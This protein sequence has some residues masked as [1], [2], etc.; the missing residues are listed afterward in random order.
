MII[1]SLFCRH[2]GASSRAALAARRWGPPVVSTDFADLPRTSNGCNRLL[3][4]PRVAMLFLSKGEMYH[5]EMWAQWFTGAIGLIPKPVLQVKHKLPN[6]C[7]TRQGLS[8]LARWCACMQLE[9]PPTACKFEVLRG[10]PRQPKLA[11][12]LYCSLMNDSG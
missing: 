7:M 12:R 5:E 3:D 11:T 9:I 1:I 6:A 4:L 8:L 2:V 10:V